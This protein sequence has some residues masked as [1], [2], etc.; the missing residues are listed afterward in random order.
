MAHVRLLFLTLVYKHQLKD[1]GSY[2]KTP[3]VM[4]E[5]DTLLAENLD[6][7]YGIIVLGRSVKSEI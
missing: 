2:D 1:S 7:R 4:F 5:N 3:G 6:Y